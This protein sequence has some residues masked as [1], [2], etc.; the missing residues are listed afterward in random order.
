M[1]QRKTMNKNSIKNLGEIVLNFFIG[2][3]TIFVIFLA[4]FGL[5][6]FFT[7]TSIIGFGARTREL[8]QDDKDAT[9]F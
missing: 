9:Q 4:F 5:V 8:F 7:F 1:K 2:I 6:M 3:G